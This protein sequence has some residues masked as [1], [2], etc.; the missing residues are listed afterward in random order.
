MSAAVAKRKEWK[1]YGDAKDD[2]PGP[3]SANT[4][5]G[6]VVKIQYISNK[7]VSFHDE[8]SFYIHIFVLLLMCFT[9][10]A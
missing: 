6:E 5:P 10:I 2:P 3:N 9:F 7:L 4:Y 8:W 1:K